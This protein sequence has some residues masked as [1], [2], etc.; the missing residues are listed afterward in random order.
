[1][2]ISLFVATTYALM[3]HSTRSENDR[4][5]RKAISQFGR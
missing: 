2:A 1:M 4:D 3:L 5:R